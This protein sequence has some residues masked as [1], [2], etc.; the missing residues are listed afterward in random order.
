MHVRTNSIKITFAIEIDF[1]TTSNVRI[2]TKMFRET[3]TNVTMI[4]EFSF[5]R[6]VGN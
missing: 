3:K 5:D 4:T 2:I 1:T 6:E